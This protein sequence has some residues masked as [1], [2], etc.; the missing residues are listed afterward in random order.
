MSDTRPTAGKRAAGKPEKRG[1]GSTADPFL[2]ILS[3]M[4][5]TAAATA[6]AEEDF[7]APA[8]LGEED[9]RDPAPEPSPGVARR[10]RGAAHAPAPPDENPPVAILE[11]VRDEPVGLGASVVEQSE[12]TAALSPPARLDA[13]PPPV[14]R[15]VDAPGGTGAAAPAHDGPGRAAPAR[16][17]RRAERTTAPNRGR[18]TQGQP[19]AESV[20]F[21]WGNKFI[22]EF[23]TW[24]LQLCVDYRLKPRQIGY[25]RFSRVAVEELMARFDRGDVPDELWQRLLNAGDEEG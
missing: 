3:R 10:E 13:V 25:S 4:R 5:P 6:A 1:S 19:A 21:S 18:P 14:D 16:D 23:Q 22:D 17:G 11:P 7:D 2:N 20:H 12:G 9:F 15:R 24:Y 8:A